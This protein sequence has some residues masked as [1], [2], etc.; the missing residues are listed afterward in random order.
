VN[1]PPSLD[2]GDPGHGPHHPDVSVRPAQ[3]QDA[4]A[5][6]A[7]HARAWRDAYTQLLP[8]RAAAALEPDDLAQSWSQAIWSPPSHQHVVL[9]ATQGPDLVGFAAISPSADADA[10]PEADGEILI[11]LV[12]PAAQRQGH[13]SRLLN[14]ATDTLRDTGFSTVRTWVPAADEPRIAFLTSAGFATDGATR[15]LDAAGD[16]TTTVRELRLSAAL[17]GR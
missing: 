16:G 1:L 14:A 8:G 4:P 10:E 6:G 11:L 15:L 13:G 3:P 12:D 17:S 5:I 9:V 2:P 7:V